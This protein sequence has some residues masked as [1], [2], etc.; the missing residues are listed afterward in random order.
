MFKGFDNLPSENICRY[1]A[2]DKYEKNGRYET[3]AVHVIPEYSVIQWF[4]E[5]VKEL[6][7]PPY[8]EEGNDSGY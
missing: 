7:K 6:E 3:E 1:D 8:N 2:H 5:P 4:Q